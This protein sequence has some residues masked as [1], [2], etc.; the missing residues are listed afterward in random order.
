M[1][2][3]LL[4]TWLRQP[5]ST[6]KAIEHRLSAVDFLYIKQVMA[7]ELGLILQPMFDIERI[8]SRLA[9]GMGS[10]ARLVQL[11]QSLVQVV[12]IRDLFLSHKKL[13]SLLKKSNKTFSK[14]LSQIIEYVDRHIST[15]R[16]Y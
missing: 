1:G 10:A 11:Q 6:K 4:R 12:K 3:R 16:T 13:P 8:V 15:G 5:L 14:Q 7:K 2:A 9:V